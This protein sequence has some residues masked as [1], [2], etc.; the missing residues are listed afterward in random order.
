MAQLQ[1]GHTPPWARALQHLT[2]LAA[3]A[4]MALVSVLSAAVFAMAS[5]ACNPGDPTAICSTHGQQIAA[6]APLYGG[7]GGAALAAFTT[8][9]WPRTHR[10]A[11]TAI[12]VTIALASW[13]TGYGIALTG[14]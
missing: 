1:D 11:C 2:I 4:G 8:Y 3:L 14:Q 6:A 12:G 9:I 13:L 10:L 7:L 5:V